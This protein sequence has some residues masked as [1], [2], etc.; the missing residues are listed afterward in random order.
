MLKSATWLKL[1]KKHETLCGECTLDRAD[2]KCVDLTFADLE[3]YAFNIL[4]GRPISWFNFF[5]SA[6]PDD[7][8]TPVSKEWK[9]AIVV[10]VH[11]SK[12]YAEGMIRSEGGA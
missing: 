10:A 9:E 8:D 5:L 7:T 11:V 4:F 3:P 12:V 1:A 2:D 6:E